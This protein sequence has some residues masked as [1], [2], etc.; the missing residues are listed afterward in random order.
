MRAGSACLAAAL[1]VHG[2]SQRL[3]VAEPA[4]GRIAVVDLAGPRVLQTIALPEGPSGLALSADGAWLY[5]TTGAASGSVRIVDTAKGAV[6]GAIAV[7]YS[8][9]APVIGRDGG[10]LYVSNRH[11]N[12]VSVIDLRSRTEVARIPVKREPDAAGLS[13]DGNL[14][15]VAN[16]LP[17]GAA[18][19]A[20][21]A[22][23][24]SVID[25]RT[26]RV[27]S[28]IQ[29][30][31][32]ATGLRDLCLSPDGRFVYVTHLLARYRLPATQIERGWIQTNAVSVID[33]ARVKLVDTFILDDF[34]LGA[35]NPWGVTCTADGKYLCVA[36]AGTHEVSVIDRLALHRKLE[37]A[38]D[39]LNDLAFLTGIRTRVPLQGIGPRGIVA[40]GASLYT[41]EYFTD[42][43]GIIDLSREGPLLARSLPLGE[44]VAPTAERRGEMLF[45]DARH[46]MEMWLSCT[47]CHPNQGRPDGLNWDLLLDA[48]GNP[49]NTK[50][51]L[52][53]HQ[54]P[55][56]TVTGIRPNAEAS[57]RSGLRNIEF[58]DR[59]EEEAQAIDAYLKS[60]QP[61]PS[62]YLENGRLSAAAERGKKVFG[63]N[64][65]P[66]CH[67]G[68]L[69][70]GLKKHNVGT[71]RGRESETA[72]DT[73]TLIEVWRTGP[74]LHDGRAA[75]ILD[76]FS[77]RD[78]GP[79]HGLRSR[80]SERKIRDLAAFVLSQ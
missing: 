76:V 39:V 53:A 35:A 74:Y 33:A 30:P 69:L 68:R 45:H 17:A 66:G 51:L 78:S 73:P 2:P 38:S 3:Y 7:G 36:H 49:K 37:T 67:A 42:S 6:T 44:P 28:E 55:P 54:T 31:D 70:T 59:P 62:P 15:F 77:G 20:H 64:G 27:T 48:V 24:I 61:L 57:V 11:H 71:G 34:N 18:N 9:N 32:G 4:A 29:L 26:R 50:S 47:S 10:T 23:V 19:A 22:A 46:T 80:L 12:N 63:E 41:A 56:T 13:A 52:L 1:V 21:V 79:V 40:V 14:L 65:C 58:A 60:L 43:L 8:P 16:Q 75:T 72:F 5:V 25:T